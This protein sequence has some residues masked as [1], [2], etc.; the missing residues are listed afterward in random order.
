M[1]I[2]GDTAP[3]AWKVAVG[4]TVSHHTPVIARSVSTV[5]AGRVIAGPR[6]HDDDDAMWT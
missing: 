3:T 2:V 5:E 4:E 6:C 1:G